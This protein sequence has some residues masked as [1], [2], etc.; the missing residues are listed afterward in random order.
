M[1][2]KRFFLLMMAGV[3]LTACDVLTVDS[4]DR[5][6]VEGWNDVGMWK[7]VAGT[8]HD[9]MPSD[10]KEHP[11]NKPSA[12]QWV[13][14]P[15]DGWCFYIPDKGT[16]QYSEGVLLGEVTKSLNAYTKQQQTFHNVAEVLTMPAHV[17]GA[18]FRAMASGLASSGSS[19]SE[20]RSEPK[21]GSSH[22]SESKGS[23]SKGSDTKGK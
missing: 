12:G 3:H 5:D 4:I 18:P 14:D 2:M 21:G 8:P 23:D 11:S 16:R 15:Q 7:K 17:A 10:C 22:H 20:R 1:I 6:D 19:R 13:V 9:Y